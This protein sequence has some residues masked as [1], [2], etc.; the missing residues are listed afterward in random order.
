MGGAV[1]F[2][3]VASSSSGEVE[4]GWELLVVSWRDPS[5]GLLR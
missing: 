4:V 2:G 1:G 3:G 5:F